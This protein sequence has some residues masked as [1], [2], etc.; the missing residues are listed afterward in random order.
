MSLL[1][2]SN[3]LREIGLLMRQKHGQTPGISASSFA[4]CPRMQQQV[5]QGQGEIKDLHEALRKQSSH[6]ILAH[7]L[8]FQESKRTLA[9]C[10]WAGV[11]FLLH[12]VRQKVSTSSGPGGTGRSMPRSLS[13]LPAAT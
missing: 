7:Q 10:T 5:K 12:R 8:L 11:P 13:S 9:H 4:A 6:A 1:E 2:P 3:V